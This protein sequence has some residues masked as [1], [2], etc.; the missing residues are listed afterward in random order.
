M[1][2]EIKAFVLDEIL[3]FVDKTNFSDEQN[4]FELGLDSLSIMRLVFFIEESFSVKIPE[5]R[6]SMESLATINSIHNLIKSLCN[7]K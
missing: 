2:E 6:I 5:D 7:T 4:L 1:R 3:P